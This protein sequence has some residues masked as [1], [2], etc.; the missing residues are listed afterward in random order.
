M[1][2]DPAAV[3]SLL[4]HPE[5]ETRRLGTQQIAEL[6]APDAA[7]LLLKA[8][9]DS[10]WRVRKEAA[11]IARVLEDRPVV[12]VALA[13][14]LGEKEDVGLRNAAVEAL[15]AI[16]TDAVPAAIA[17][18]RG[19]DADGRKLAVEVLAGVP[20]EGGTHELVRALRDADANVRSAAA[21]A[22]G[23]AS[24]A[25]GV[26]AQLAAT[27]LE[28]ALGAD[29]KITQ[30]A[31]LS[32]LARLGA[33]LPWRVLAPLAQDPVLR[34]YA[35]GAAG[36]SEEREAFVALA[37]AIEDGSPA[38]S[39]EAL[40]ALSQCAS[41]TTNES[42]VAA[43]REVIGRSAVASERIRAHAR[44]EVAPVR[45]AG[46]VLLG[47]VRDPADVPLLVEALGD[48]EAGSAAETALL[49]FGKTAVGALLE[50]GRASSQ[51]VRA[52]TITLVPMLTKT[53][54][55]PTRDALYDA[56]GDPSPAVVMASIATL[57]AT[58]GA[59][60]LDRIA[61]FA[62]H[63]DS[64]VAKTA[65]AAARSLTPRFPSE[66]RAL[67]A[68]L[69]AKGS[70]AALGCVLLGALAE[71]DNE[72]GRTPEETDLVFLRAAAAHE[73]AAA[74]RAAVEALAIL[75][76]P[77]AAEVVTLAVA[78]EEPEVCFAAVRAL[79]RLGLAEPLVGLVGTTHDGGLLA[80]A[81]RALAEADPLAAYESAR[82]LVR[83]A[84]P[85]VACAAVVALGAMPGPRRED[86]L[87]EAL[88]HENAEVVK[89][90]LF[91][92]SRLLDARTLS[93]FALC[94]DHDSW[95]VR[96]LAVELLGNAG[97][98]SARSL[99]RARLER[100]KDELVRDAIGAALAARPAQGGAG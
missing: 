6:R 7:A 37:H 44:S 23:S 63:F 54:D 10:D 75:G 99:L 9:A 100:E 71:V 93:R 28:E 2:H 89:A 1:S 38:V 92:L 31:A 85:V 53:S 77:A 64:G 32:A 27:A 55:R 16:G 78:D 50:A 79:G 8:L 67:R 98:D 45:A 74:R 60:D 65:C 49:L 48:E 34:R 62:K 18:L 29:D 22:L 35:I 80:V 95:E 33:K 39:T 61:V 3:R 21:E 58:G 96:R 56:L 17:A 51:P 59:G 90:A 57:G 4:E 73:N 12:L 68:R 46:L 24:A 81:L 91:E 83:A 36:R 72:G 14:A 47:L 82:P 42:N 40:L 84:E 25:G 11:S 26:A 30:L 97:G 87:F 66:A 20:D 76:G 52:A 19:L 15:V 86:A 13:G 5:P 41:R 88:D 69:D 70:L 43:A 94:L